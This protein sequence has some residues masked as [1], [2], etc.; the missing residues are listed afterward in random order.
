MTETETRIPAMPALESR[1]VG[2]GTAL[3]VHPF[4]VIVMVLILVGGAAAYGLVRKPV[5][6]ATARL[7]VGTIDITSPGALSGY[8]VAAPALASSYSRVI[9][10]D[11]VV[12]PVSRMTHLS[13]STVRGRLSATPIPQSPV[14]EVQATGPSANDAV[15]LANSGSTA[16]INYVV[17]INRN[18]PDTGRLFREFKAA[19]AR[20]ENAQQKARKLSSQVGAA[21]HPSAAQINALV[22]ARAAVDAANAS[23]QALRS[24]YAQSLAGQSATQLVQLLSAASGA[25]SDRLPRLE[26][27][28]FVALVAGLIVGTALATLRA[29]RWAAR[30]SP[31][32]AGSFVADPD[33]TTAD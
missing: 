9:G 22:R 27:F 31:D 14:I 25:T 21:K 24:T 10:A 23:A 4:I 13:P 8:A 16:L 2:V 5:Y 6:T 32:T 1:A 18:N 12:R 28:L 15:N 11:A 17:Q 19:A 30:T 20:F 7:T 29:R 26:I 3:R 33:P